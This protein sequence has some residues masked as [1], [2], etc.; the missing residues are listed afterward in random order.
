MQYFSTFAHKVLYKAMNHR[1]CL[2][3]F[4]YPFGFFFFFIL[5]SFPSKKKVSGFQDGKMEQNCTR[6]NQRLLS[7]SLSPSFSRSLSL[8]CMRD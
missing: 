3:I 5:F 4:V 6:I 8:D 7:L 1:M 2:P